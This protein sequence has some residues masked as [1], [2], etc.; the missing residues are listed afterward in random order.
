ME[1]VGCGADMVMT[2]V[3]ALC[4]N[5]QCIILNFKTDDGVEIIGA[6]D[7]NAQI[8]SSR[9]RVGSSQIN[10]LTKGHSAFGR[11]SC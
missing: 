2:V 4:I 9:S 8:Y 5:D 7:L 10:T 11:H 6:V 1:A 3:V